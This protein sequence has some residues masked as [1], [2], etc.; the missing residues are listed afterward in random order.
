[1]GRLVQAQTGLL[2][3]AGLE[4]YEPKVPLWDIKIP[5]EEPEPEE[6]E[7]KGPCELT[8]LLS[9]LSAV[10]L[11]AWLSSVLRPVFCIQTQLRLCLFDKAKAAPLLL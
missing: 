8:P 7:Q 5:I 6:D 10:R 9:F 2:L 4:E 3:E 11:L 1:M